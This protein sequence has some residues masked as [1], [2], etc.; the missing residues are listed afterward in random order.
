METLKCKSNKNMRK[1]NQTI[2][3]NNGDLQLQPVWTWRRRPCYW[4]SQGFSES[5]LLHSWTGSPGGWNCHHKEA[6]AIDLPCLEQHPT[7][8]PLAWNAQ[9][10]SPSAPHHPIK[11]HFKS[12]VPPDPLSICSLF[13][14]FSLVLLF[15]SSTASQEK[16]SVWRIPSFLLMFWHAALLSFGKE[17]VFWCTSLLPFCKELGLPNE[18]SKIAYYKSDSNKQMLLVT[19]YTGHLP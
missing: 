18:S 7:M 14:L 13:H 8:E 3:C 15:M 12:I 1:W 9:S 5:H 19:F 10:L 2:G 11:H 17:L 16:N 6:A 4:D